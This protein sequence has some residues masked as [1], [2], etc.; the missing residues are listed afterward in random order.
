MLSRVDTVEVDE[1]DVAE[2]LRILQVEMVPI[3]EAAGAGSGGILQGVK[4]L[5]TPV[6]V[7]CVWTCE[8]FVA[9][10]QIRRNLVLDPDWYAC[11]EKLNRIRGSGLRRFYGA[12]DPPQRDTG[13]GPA[14][15]RFETY[16]FLPGATADQR[17]QLADVLLE[18]G[19]RIP[20]V[21]HSAVGWNRSEA[22][23]ELVWEHFFDS[24]AAYRRYMVHPYHAE[25]ID[26]YVLADSPERVVETAKGAGLFGYR[27]SGHPFL[28]GD[29]FLAAPARIVVLFD[30][31][32]DVA[33]IDE[34][35]QRL[36]EACS[37]ADTRG[38]GWGPNSMA[39]AWYDAETTL[40][41]LPP[42]WNHVWEAGLGAAPSDDLGETIAALLLEAGARTT[43]TLHY[44]V[45]RRPGARA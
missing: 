34:L 26:R 44:E 39:S 30:L 38:T 16:A 17:R 10:N 20:E 33:D 37:P 43:R 24:P 8:G 19:Q 12:A 13:A 35:S 27:C 41:G 9:W 3:M 22:S 25:L 2:Y 21:N 40:P 31:D 45:V 11:A 29:P 18:S 7:Q 4:D 36:A 14:I 1:D 42:R 23:S 28:D 5:G 32:A 15:R 6:T